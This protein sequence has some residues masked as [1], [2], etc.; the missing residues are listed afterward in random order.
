[1]CTLPTSAS[2]LMPNLYF[3]RM[4][5]QGWSG[6]GHGRCDVLKTSQWW[7]RL[8][9][10]R[11]GETR[12]VLC[13][14]RECKPPPSAMT[15]LPSSSQP[16]SLPGSRYVVSS[17]KKIGALCDQSDCHAIWLFVISQQGEEQRIRFVEVG[18]RRCDVG[19]GSNRRREFGGEFGT[20]RGACFHRRPV[21]LRTFFTH[22]SSPSL[23]HNPPSCRPISPEIDTLRRRKIRCIPRNQW[24]RAV[25]RIIA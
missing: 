24:A 21:H 10:I 19:D 18:Y 22:P 17:Q 7:L 13:V 4:E 2:S 1:M 6:E 9:S 3:H 15:V 5:R 23:T 8:R 20:C 12:A 25:E 11:G 16:P 14:R